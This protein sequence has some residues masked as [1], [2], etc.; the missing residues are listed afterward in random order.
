[1]AEALV[2]DRPNFHDNASRGLKVRGSRQC[3]HP[4]TDCGRQPRRRALPAMLIFFALGAMQ[5]NKLQD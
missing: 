2:P 3:A 5:S 1:M 4:V